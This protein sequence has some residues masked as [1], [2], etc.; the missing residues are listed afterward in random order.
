MH[1]LCRV[2]RVT[3]G[4]PITRGTPICMGYLILY[5]VPLFV[6][7]TSNSAGYLKSRRAPRIMRGTSDC[8]GTIPL[9]DTWRFTVFPIFPS[10]RNGS[11]QVQSFSA[12]I[13]LV[14]LARQFMLIVPHN[15]PILFN[16]SFC[17]LS[18]LCLSACG[19]I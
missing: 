17:F 1:P 14:D 2:P 10:N 3:W 13:S 11:A 12:L 15:W 7:D 9:V 6:W 5:G 4:T 18:M 8:A 16:V 19:C